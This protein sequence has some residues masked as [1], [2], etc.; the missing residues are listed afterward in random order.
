MKLLFNAH[1][2]TMDLAKP[3][4]E[5]VAIDQG[6]IIAVGKNDEILSLAGQDS[7]QENMGGMVIW[8][9]L[10]DAHLHL[11]NY[12]L[13]M[14]MVDCETTTRE[15]CL[16]RV[17]ERA[18]KAEPGE[19]IRGH[20]WNQNTWENGLGN[21]IELD[22]VAPHNPVFLTQKSLHAGWANSMALR[23]AGID[24][25]T[26]DPSDGKID[27]DS[28]GNPTG[29]LLEGAYPIVEM[30]IPTPTLE[31]VAEGHLHAQEALWKM[32][33]TG[34]HDFDRR[35]SFMALELLSEHKNL[36]LRVVKSIPVEDLPHAAA[37]GLRTGFGNEFL[38]IGSVKLFADGALG[39]QSAAMFQAYSGSDQVGM[40]FLDGEQIFEIGQT[41]AASG[42][43]LATHAIG[44]RANH[45]VING[46]EQLRHYEQEKHLPHLRHRLE[47]V[48]IIHPD[49]QARLAKNGIIAS[50]QPIHATSDMFM[51]D[52]FWGARCANAYAWRTILEQQTPYAF[53]SDAPVE[54]PN[55][56][57]GLHAAVTRRRA[58]GDPNPDGWY[59]EQRL[60]L[61]QALEGYTLGPAYAAGMEHQVGK[62]MPGFFADLIVL[63]QNPFDLAAQELFQVK[64]CATM[65][66]GEWVWKQ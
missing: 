58:N 28:E 59:S 60:T 55:P 36:K 4:V 29:I 5:A 53:G 45:E 47:H 25:N 31:K 13:S 8:P 66:A 64:P 23:L 21:A 15:E 20:G 54:S 42:L 44:D 48:Q 24:A 14:G 34:V 12:A 41:A 18:A 50:M 62:L 17:A 9:G 38:R 33:L 56:F 43:S 2:K 6:Q 32:G 52:R 19:W 30:A 39:P 61:Q 40:L 46:Y 35:S 63:D 37:V 49:D 11:E 27:R 26:K 57:F 7:S 3:Y 16:R 51:A 10:T 22:R 65:V 1:I